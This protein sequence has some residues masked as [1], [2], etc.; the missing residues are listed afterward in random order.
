MKAVNQHRND[1]VCSLHEPSASCICKGKERKK[2]E[3]GS[4]AAV[5]MTKSGRKQIGETLIIEIPDNWT[6]K[7]TPYLKKKARKNFGRR[8]AIEPVIGHLKSDFQL[9]RNYLKGAIGET[10]NLLL[11]AA[12]VNIRK[13]MR[14]SAHHHRY[15]LSFIFFW[16]FAPETDFS[17][18]LDRVPPRSRRVN[19]ILALACKHGKGMLQ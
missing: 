5:A 15:Y 3:F 6:T 4:K 9:A 11:S 8:S 13:W 14:A 7:K 17:Q 16:I 10:T 18:L 12:A 19:C 1:K 2:Y